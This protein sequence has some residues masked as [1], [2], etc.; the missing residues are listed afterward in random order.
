[1]NKT[2]IWKV[3]KSSYVDEDSEN[4]FLNWFIVFSDELCSLVVEGL[5][6]KLNFSYDNYSFLR[7]DPEYAI[8]FD[9][10][11]AYF[12][13]NPIYEKVEEKAIVFEVSI[14][15]LKLKKFLFF[16][17]KFEPEKEIFDKFDKAVMEIAE[18]NNIDVSYL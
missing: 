3:P 14:S 1:M 10:K 7:D 11:E 18:E 9:E 17:R 4:N 16:Y 6:K 13:V 15:A 8:S 12:L 5:R 2:C